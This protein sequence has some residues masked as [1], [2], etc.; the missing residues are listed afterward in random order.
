M[1][2]GRRIDIQE[3]L[4]GENSNVLTNSVQST[5]NG[6]SPGSVH[7]PNEPTDG[8]ALSWFYMRAAYGQEHRAETIL[9]GMGIETYIPLFKQERRYGEKTIVKKVN[10]IPNSIFVHSTEE[11]LHRFIGKDPLSFFH[12]YYLKQTDKNGLVR[13]KP[14]VIPD[15]E[16]HSFMLWNDTE[17]NDKIFQPDGAFDF[18]EHDRVRVREGRFADFEGHVIRYKGQT[19]VGVCIE[20]MGSFFTAYIPKN[21]LTKIEGERC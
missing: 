1:G 14:I 5:L 16:M 19:R 17:S 2:N 3:V 20:G 9:Q 7:N 12:H 15:T 18:E 8:E 13:R 10:V 4:A 11:R 6:V 21:L